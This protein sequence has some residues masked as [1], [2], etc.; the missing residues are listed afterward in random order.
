MYKFTEKE[1]EWLKK[2]KEE[3]DIYEIEVDNDSI[4][5]VKRNDEGYFEKEFTFHEWGEHFLITLL[6]HLGYKADYV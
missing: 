6:N 1:I 5:V 2:C 4:S 3:P